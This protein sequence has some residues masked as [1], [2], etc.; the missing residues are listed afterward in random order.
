MGQSITDPK[1]V[2]DLMARM[3]RIE[4][5]A[6]GIQR[7]LEQGRSC[8]DL[9]TQLTALRNAV[10]KVATHVVLQNLESCLFDE[11]RGVDPRE[12]MEEARRLLLR[13]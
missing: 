2:K 5:Q 10:E 4:G 7:M 3:R 6:R 9:V 13:L 8:D 12:A 11:S 1:V